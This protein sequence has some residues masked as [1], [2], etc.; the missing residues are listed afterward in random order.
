M[1]VLICLITMETC[2][3]KNKEKKYEKKNERPN[4]K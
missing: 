2:S 1:M 3:E 4:G